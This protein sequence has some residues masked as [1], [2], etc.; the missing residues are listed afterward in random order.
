MDILQSCVLTLVACVYTA[1]HLNIPD[2]RSWSSQLARKGRAV[3]I[4]VLAPEIALFSAAVQLFQAWD[5]KNAMI[6]LQMQS[7]DEE[8]RKV[9]ILKSESNLP[10]SF[11]LTSLRAD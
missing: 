1:L 3:F 10:Y 7:D 9:G 4:T 5:F 6:D 2:R 11:L 8:V